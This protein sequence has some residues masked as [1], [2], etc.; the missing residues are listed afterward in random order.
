MP[1]RHSNKNEQHEENEETSKRS[2][3]QHRTRVAVMEA[4]K[5]SDAERRELRCQQRNLAKNLATTEGIEDVHSEKFDQV[6]HKNNSLWSQVRFPREA[7]LDAD[8][9]E[10]IGSKA[11]RQVDKLISVPRY[12]AERLVMKLR[13]KCPRGGGGGIDWSVLGREVG[14]CFNALPSVF[15]LS[16]PIQ[17]VKDYRPKERRKPVRHVEDDV[18][19]EEPEEV[20]QRK[21]NKTDENK[22]SAVEKQMKTMNKVLKKNCE[23]GRKR[24]LD[25]LCKEFNV[26]SYEEL[27]NNEDPSMKKRAL[28][29]FKSMGPDK[30]CA[31]QF[32]FNPESFTQT[33]ENIF[34]MS[35]MVKKGNAEIGVRKEEDC[36]ET[37]G[38]MP[39]PWLKA[40]KTRDEEHSSGNVGSAKQAIV[41]LN[42]KDWRDMCKTFEVVKGDIPQRDKTK[43]R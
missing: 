26:N 35:F 3:R 25:A 7:V 39:G 30:I 17:L 12:D 14:S 15:F 2:K 42:L 27:V 32:L 37:E 23:E 13:S 38:V 40:K 6:R 22:L 31:V 19:E 34:S 11:S 43:S 18:E 36:R 41:A 28:K 4:S 1:T 29:K 8:N 33:V 9:V 21:K 20:H 24:G 16:G 5:Q 10:I